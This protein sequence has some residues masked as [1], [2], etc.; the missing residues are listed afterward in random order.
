M[1]KLDTRIHG[2]G[3]ERHHMGFNSVFFGVCVSPT[4]LLPQLETRSVPISVY[5]HLEMT[6]LVQLR[7]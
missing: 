4:P 7:I 2:N 5:C 6:F 1:T 3:V